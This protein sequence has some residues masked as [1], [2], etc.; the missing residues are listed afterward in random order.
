MN[1]QQ[2]LLDFHRRVHQ[3]FALLLEHCR[4]L[5]G[6]EL[7][8]EMK[9]FGYPT[10]RLQLHHMIGAEKYWIGVLQDKIDVDEDEDLYP[11]IGSLET[12]RKQVFLMTEIFLNSSYTEELETPRLMTTWGGNEK[13]LNPTH[14][15]LRT[16]THIYH[17]QGQVLAMCRLLGKPC[18]GLDYP[19]D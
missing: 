16:Q 7:N 3:S 14:V 4:N 5:T 15:F 10:I 19:I 17:H 12:Y 13:L 18:I 11:T 9:G 6:E 8:R 2:F 1:I